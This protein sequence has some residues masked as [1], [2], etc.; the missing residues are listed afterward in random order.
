MSTLRGQITLPK[1]IRMSLAVYDATSQAPRLAIEDY[2]AVRRLKRRRG[3]NRGWARRIVPGW[4]P[5]LKPA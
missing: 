4:T 2:R 3:Q 1:F 5:E